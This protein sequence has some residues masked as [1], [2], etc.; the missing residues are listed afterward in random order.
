MEPRF[1][2]PSFF[3]GLKNMSAAPCRSL[4]R[5]ASKSDI[6][7]ETLP[8]TIHVQMLKGRGLSP[9]DSNGLSDPYAVLQ[10]GITSAKTKTIRKTL[11]P[12]WNETL[13]LGSLSAAEKQIEV[14]VWDWDYLAR[15]HDFIGQFSI[16][17]AAPEFTLSS[18][19][20]SSII[21]TPK[22]FVFL[23]LLFQTTTL[24]LTL[25]LTFVVENKKVL[26]NTT[27]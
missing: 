13:T 16:N 17:L 27:V 3:F 25:T 14:K 7:G 4:Y 11:N 5:K 6:G 24:G 1:S 18:S 21:G 10:Y 15:K 23:L 19:S 20:P 26:F 9:R 2:S 8:I 12:E 22:W